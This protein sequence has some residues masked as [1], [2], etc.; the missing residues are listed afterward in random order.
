[1]GKRIIWRCDLFGC[2]KEAEGETLG[3]LPPGWLEASFFNERW[4]RYVFAPMPTSQSGARK[5]T[6]TMRA[7]L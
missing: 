5:E 1:M 3:I 7:D 2:G 6:G 4:Y